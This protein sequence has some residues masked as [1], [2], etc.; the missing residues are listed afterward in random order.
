MEA[1][2]DF[3]NGIKTSFGTAFGSFAVDRIFPALIVWI[4]LYVIIKIIMRIVKKAIEQGRLDK[5]LHGFIRASI[6]I[7]LYI[8]A[9]II[10]VGVLGIPITSLVAVLSVVGLAVSLAVQNSLV[11]LVGGVTILVTKPFKVDDYIETNDI[12]GTV[13]E[14]GM[15]YTILATPDKKNIFV[16]NGKITEGKVV[17]FSSEKKRKVVFKF[18]A[19]YDDDINKVK[20]ALLEVADGDKRILTTPEPFANVFSY[21][22]SSIEYI[23]TVWAKNADYWDVY[24]YV[25]E[26][27][28]HSFDKNGITMTYNHL[29]VHVVEK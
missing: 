4:I 24:Y 15:F 20:A 5:N 9:T 21:Q 13:L 16:P 8:I 29:N 10:I 12:G 7:T 14:I 26:A 1:F 22:D 3:I 18:N 25:M 28:K 11:N 27:V 23:F 17:N 6:E 2:S 19:S